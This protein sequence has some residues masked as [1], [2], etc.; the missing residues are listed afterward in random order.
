MDEDGPEAS[1]G[2]WEGAVHEDTVVR[3][4]ACNYRITHPKRGSRWVAR[5]LIADKLMSPPKSKTV[6]LAL[7][8]AGRKVRRWWAEM[9]TAPSKSK[10]SKR[11]RKALKRLWINSEVRHNFQTRNDFVGI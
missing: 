9:E 1:A 6:E 8:S 2:A 4:A 10:L 5:R 7:E 3:E 11:Q